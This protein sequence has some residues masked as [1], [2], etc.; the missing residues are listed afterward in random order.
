MI[1]PG[2]SSAYLLMWETGTADLPWEY[3]TYH[4]SDEMAIDYASRV[5]ASSKALQA[6]CLSLLVWR[7]AHTPN[8]RLVARITLTT[9]TQVTVERETPK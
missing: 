8:E 4:A 2:K 6:G 1:P 9:N 3:E 5:F 7:E